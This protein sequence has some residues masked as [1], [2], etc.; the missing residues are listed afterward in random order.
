MKPLL[1]FLLEPEHKYGI[2]SF[3]ICPSKGTYI[4]HEIVESDRDPLEKTDLLRLALHY[5]TTPRHL[6]YQDLRKRTVLMIA[7]S[8][9]NLGSARLLVEAGADIDFEMSDSKNVRNS[10][11][12]NDNGDEHKHDEAYERMKE[13][14]D[15]LKD[16]PHCLVDVR[17][18]SNLLMDLDREELVSRNR[19]LFQNLA[20]GNVHLTRS[21]RFPTKTH[22]AT[23]PSRQSQPFDPVV[24]QPE[25]FVRIASCMILKPRPKYRIY[26]AGMVMDNPVR[27]TGIR[28]LYKDKEIELDV[29]YTLSLCI[30]VAQAI[31]L[32]HDRGFIH[33]S[34]DPDQVWVVEQN[35][36]TSLFK[37]AEAVLTARW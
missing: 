8:T 17:P 4:L 20:S 37:L 24:K 36:T 33:G 21:T 34:V 1:K 7:V 16:K 32:L 9:L 11:I 12:L 22:K 30:D 35:D 18:L 23:D 6:N 2:S 3:I 5:F 31:A 28:T 27:N 26:T 15:E 14:L 29:P 13:F 19:F 10:K 25:Y